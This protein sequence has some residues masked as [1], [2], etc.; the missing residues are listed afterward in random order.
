MG[1]YVNMKNIIEVIGGEEKL[2]EELPELDIRGVMETYRAI[3]KTADEIR[4]VERLTRKQSCG[5]WRDMQGRSVMSTG[6]RG[7]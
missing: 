7:A 4:F 1:V 5:R 2:A 6:L 3:P